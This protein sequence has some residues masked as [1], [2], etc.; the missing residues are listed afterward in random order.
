MTN[1][2]QI[3][4]IAAAFVDRPIDLLIHNAGVGK[5]MPED[6]IMN[7]NVQAPF[8]VISAVFPAVQASRQKKIA[9]ISSQLGSREKYGAGNVPRNPYGASK[10]LLNDRF[11]LEEVGWRALGVSGLVVHPGWVVTDMGGPGADITVDESVSGMYGVFNNLSL[12]NSG[13]FVT[14]TGETHPW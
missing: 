11:R 8:E 3:G 5:S 13:S 9:I 4:T 1:S 2:E 7:V 14:Y 10:C 12:D 6:V